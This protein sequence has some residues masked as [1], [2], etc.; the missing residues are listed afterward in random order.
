LQDCEAGI[1]R[2]PLS[3]SRDWRHQKNRN[4]PGP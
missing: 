2:C 1:E 3:V 4:E